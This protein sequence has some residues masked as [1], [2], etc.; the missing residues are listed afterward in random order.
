MNV[1]SQFILFVISHSLEI[2]IISIHYI[3]CKQKLDSKFVYIKKISFGVCIPFVT[4]V[5]MLKYCGNT[6]NAQ[7]NQFIH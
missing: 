3:I 4:Q 1:L 2:M 7:V 6:Q 5:T